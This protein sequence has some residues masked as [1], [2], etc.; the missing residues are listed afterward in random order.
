MPVREFYDR[1]EAEFFMT[2]LEVRNIPFEVK[3]DYC[4][5]EPVFKV[6]YSNPE[7]TRLEVVTCRGLDMWRVVG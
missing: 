5:A 7:T 4:R 2:T 1:D 3:Y 6:A